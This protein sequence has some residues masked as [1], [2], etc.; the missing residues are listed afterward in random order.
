MKKVLRSFALGLLAGGLVGLWCGMNIGKD[1]PL[2]SNPFAEPSIGEQAERALTGAYEGAA[3]A[4]D[5]VGNAIE[6]TIDKVANGL[7]RDG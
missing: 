5:E 1:K 2:F 4:V 6:Q 7:R 3:Q